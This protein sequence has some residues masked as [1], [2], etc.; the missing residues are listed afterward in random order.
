MAATPLDPAVVEQIYARGG[1]GRAAWKAGDLAAAEADFL[2][3][4]ALLPEPRPSQD[5]AQSMSG[6]LVT[7]FRDTKQV[8]K[9][10]HW[11]G[12]MRQAYG[13][14]D[15]TGYVDFVAAT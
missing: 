1:S 4:W 6:A 9:A 5:Y 8:D 10:R 12:V 7:F 3:A 13:P 14:E 2:A 15:G 11:L